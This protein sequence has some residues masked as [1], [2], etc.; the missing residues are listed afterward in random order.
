MTTGKWHHK[1]RPSEYYLG[2]ILRAFD[3]AKE[4]HFQAVPGPITPS[5]L[6]DNVVM[7]CLRSQGG[8]RM[9]FEWDRRN[10]VNRVGDILEVIEAGLVPGLRIERQNGK[11]VVVSP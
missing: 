11:A 2:A 9:M 3:R 1:D 6:W 10:N 4:K 7:E 5:E 8:F